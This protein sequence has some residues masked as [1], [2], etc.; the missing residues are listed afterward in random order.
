MS[1]YLDMSLEHRKI[2][3][4]GLGS[5]LGLRPWEPPRPHAGI[6]LYTPPLVKVQTQYTTVLCS[7]LTRTAVL[8]KIAS[9]KVQFSQS[10]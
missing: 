8:D 6:T 2:P 3:A 1:V 7:G 5:S 10:Q 9:H 4:F